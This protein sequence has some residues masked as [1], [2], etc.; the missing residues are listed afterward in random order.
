MPRYVVKFGEGQ[1]L[2]WSTVVDAP[3]VY[4]TKSREEAVMDF[5]ADR[6]ER[7]DKGGT[8]APQFLTL[9]DIANYNRA[10]DDETCITI[11]EIIEKYTLKDKPND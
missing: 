2:E 7:A 3:V 10:G 6:I 9:E 8:S 1:Y 4:M 11:P 5:G